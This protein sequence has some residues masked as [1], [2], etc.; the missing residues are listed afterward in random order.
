[1]EVL[2]DE[3]AGFCHGVKKTIQATEK[4][5]E[6]FP[7]N[8]IYVLGEI[9]HNPIE[10]SRLGKMGMKTASY[11]DLE[12]IA[13]DKNAKLIIRAHGEPPKT[14]KD[15]EE[16]GIYTIDATCPKVM[17]LQ[18]LVKR[19]YEQ[20]H[21]ILIYGKYNHAE[22]IGL[23]GV[24]DDNCTV[25]KLES[26]AEN[27]ELS[28]EKIYLLSQTT[29]NQAQFLKTKAII[30]RRIELLNKEREANGETSIELIFNDT[31]CKSVTNRE[32]SL[33]AFAKKCDVIVFV[34]GRNSS[35]GKYL[36]QTA[37]SANKNTFFVEKIEEVQIDWFKD[38]KVIGVSGATS[39]PRWYMEELKT[40]IEKMI[41]V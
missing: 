27:V 1:M 28:N 9:I 10:I 24:C 40:E 38:A 19:H 4:L 17:H 21:Q 7:D 31:I 25:L 30:E 5:L 23:R 11:D 8:D 12:R 13:E 2:I 3:T 16:K 22:T 6:Q 29:M 36:F 41:E 35:N 37:E 15:T 32:S 26:D 39:T 34:S 18:K 20:G 33:I 14:Y